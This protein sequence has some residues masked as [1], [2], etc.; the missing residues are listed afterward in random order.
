MVLQYKF[1]LNGTDITSYV[2]TGT[3]ITLT[4]NNDSGNTA[5]LV[6]NSD[7]DSFFTIQAGQI[8]IISR[9]ETDPTEDIVFKGNIK[10]I[11]NDNNNN[12]FIK[13]KD[14]LHQF[15]YKLFT[16]SYD[17]DI[18]TE[19]GEASAIF[20][21][22]VTNGGFTPSV[23]SSGTTNSDITLQKFISKKN[24]RLDRLNLISKILNWVFYYDYNNDWVRLEP[25]GYEDYS[26][27]L[28]VGT[29]ILNVPKWEDDLEAVRNN[30]TVEGA[31]IL[32]T[33]QE[34]ETGDGTIKEFGFSYEPETT[35]LSVAGTLQVRGAPESSGE[36][37]YVVDIENKTYTFGTAPTAGQ[38]II[39][40]YTTRIPMPVQNKSPSSINLYGL[41]QEEI[42]TFKDVVNVTDAETRVQQL[43]E[44]LEYAP[45]MASIFTIETGIRPGMKVNITDSIH[46]LKSGEYIVYS[47]NINYGEPYDTVEIGTPKFNVQDLFRTIDERLKSLETVDS[48]L[49][50]ILLQLI[51]FTHL[52]DYDRYSIVTEK[53]A[54]SGGVYG[55]QSLGVYGEG[56]Y[57]DVT[58]FV[59]GDTNYAVLGTSSL[60]EA[61]G[62]WAEQYEEIYWS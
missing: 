42:Y 19:A 37:D 58:S 45:T 35:D 47:I 26:T 57:G 41:E 33:R 28:I 3:K 49:S 52:E 13:C 34:T 27:S 21:D 8:I 56:L 62:A 40:N 10:I 50:E 25:K 36:Y 38:S 15:K 6:I 31:Y 22:I 29:N 51:N 43:L 53:K 5:N 17:I 7:I 61:G 59:L 46:P 24:S 54:M 1:T 60:G 14:L 2:L 20:A 12:Y 55:H 4:R 44:L 32:D 18:D 39:M 30:I 16:Y 9:G 23:V 11:D 48:K